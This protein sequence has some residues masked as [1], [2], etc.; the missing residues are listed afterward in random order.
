MS[1][2]SIVSTFGSTS[3]DV[4][5]RGNGRPRFPRH[6]PPCPTPPLSPRQKKLDNWQRRAT[7][8]TYRK[9]A[10]EQKAK[11]REKKKK[12]KSESRCETESVVT[13]RRCAS[14]WPTLIKSITVRPTSRIDSVTHV[15]PVVTGPFPTPTPNGNNN[16]NNNHN[17]NNN[18]SNN[19]ERSTRHAL[20]SHSN[21][22]ST[23]RWRFLSLFL[24]FFCF[25][26]GLN[27]VF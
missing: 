27:Q 20:V 19:N 12:N 13:W 21:I 8:F 22:Q 24:L 17:N 16:N 4:N 7:S 9:E 10:G 18:N 15:T 25:F 3:V 26:F 6:L 2:I 23:N 14:Q 1:S 11:P 5:P